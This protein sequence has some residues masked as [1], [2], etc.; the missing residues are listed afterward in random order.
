MCAGKVARIT[1]E[2]AWDE[3]AAKFA[4]LLVEMKAMK[5]KHQNL[6][7]THKLIEEHSQKFEDR[8]QALEMQL[9]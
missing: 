8:N 9:V 7:D 2:K 1:A 6:E 3:M 5:V 4:A